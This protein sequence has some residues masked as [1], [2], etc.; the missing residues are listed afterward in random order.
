MATKITVSA[1]RKIIAEEIENAGARP[2]P[3]GW[4]LLTGPAL[5]KFLRVFAERFSGHENPRVYAQ[6]FGR[7]TVFASDSGVV[8]LY[9]AGDDGLIYSA[10]EMSLPK[11]SSPV[12]N[13]LLQAATMGLSEDLTDL[14]VYVNGRLG[15]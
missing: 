5:Q 14:G 10:K 15:R 2:A 11:T 9:V 6:K 3:Q 13:A 7:K 1:L 12:I 8:R 4:D